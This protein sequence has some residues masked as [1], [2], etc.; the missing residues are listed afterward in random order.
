MKIHVL[1]FIVGVWYVTSTICVINSKIVLEKKGS[2]VILTYG[3]F[4]FSTLVSLIG[5]FRLKIDKVNFFS[6]IA[7]IAYA[8]GFLL[9]NLNLNT[10][11]A[12]MSEIMR[13]A[14]PLT[15]TGLIF[16]HNCIMKEYTNTYDFSVILLLLGFMTIIYGADMKMQDVFIAMTC[17]LLFSSRSVFAKISN[18]SIESLYIYQNIFSVI[19]GLPFLVYSL[20]ETKKRY[21]NNTFS[22]EFWIS[23]IAFS[24]Y[25]ASSLIVLNATD[26][27]THSTFNSFRRIVTIFMSALFLANYVNAIVVCGLLLSI[28]GSLWRIICVIIFKKHEDEQVNILINDNE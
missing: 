2:I 24:A 22:T 4:I 19:L 11:D 10:I 9:L 25:N 28:I 20:Y 15:T 18:I 6:I 3:Q 16:V 8:L 27:L 7:S 23:C 17:N 14:E 26:P 13:T 12:Y 5:L 1:A 21:I